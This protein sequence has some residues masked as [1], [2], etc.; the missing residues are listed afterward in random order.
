MFTITHQEY[1]LLAQYI[2][3]HFGIYLKPEKKPLIVGRLATLLTRENCKDF[4]EYYQFLLND[5]TGMASIDLINRMSTNHTYFLREMEHF[6][7][8]REHVLPKLEITYQDEMELRIWSAGCSSGEEPY[9][10]S[11]VLAEY[12][13]GRYTLWDTGILATDISYDV[14]KT[15][16]KGIYSKEKTMNIPIEWKNKYLKSYDDTHDI[17][18]D[19]IRN[20]VIYKRL[21]LM[22]RSFPFKKK[23][24]V[25][26][27][28]NVMIYFD[29]ET[30]RELVQ[31]FYDLTEDGGY[32]FIG[33]SESLTGIHDAYQYIMPSVYQKK[34]GN[35][36]GE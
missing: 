19:K 7:Y 18:Q 10:M 35:H 20:N 22:D 33:M 15:A 11:M 21:N 23:F 30:K 27:C 31:K 32:L 34:G 6:Y 28:R 1:E 13:Q 3:S 8:L 16:Y 26:F 25:I 5:K 2:H 17:F 4:S 29:K 14:L 24:Q 12:F 9:T 36:L